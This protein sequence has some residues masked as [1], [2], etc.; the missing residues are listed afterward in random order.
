MRDPYVYVASGA[1]AKEKEGGYPHVHVDPC[2]QIFRDRVG[3]GEPMDRGKLYKGLPSDCNR[4]DSGF[5]RI[6][7]T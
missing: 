1:S 4:D 2:S 7:D 6:G 5:P 3:A